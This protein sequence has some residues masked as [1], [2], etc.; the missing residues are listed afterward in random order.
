MTQEQ[1]RAAFLSAIERIRQMDARVVEEPDPIRQ[2]L[3]ELYVSIA[4][5]TPHNSFKT[6]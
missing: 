3:L 4:L 2:T 5:S 6:T 1:F